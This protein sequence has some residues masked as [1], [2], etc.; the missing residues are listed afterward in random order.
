M[1]NNIVDPDGDVILKLEYPNDPFALE[2]GSPRTRAQSPNSTALTKDDSSLNTLSSL[3]DNAEPGEGDKSELVTFRVSSRHLALA[4]PVFKSALTGEWKESVKTEGEHQINSEGWDTTALS[5]FLKAIHCQYRQ[6]PRSLELE[7]LAKVAVIVDYYAAHQ[8]IEILGPIW[9]NALRSWLPTTTC[10]YRT[11]AL[12][13]CISWVFG[14]SSAFETAT[15]VAI[16]HGHSN[17]TD[18]G[19][20]I[21]GR[22][23][24]DIN[25]NKMLQVSMVFTRLSTLQ[26]DLLDSR[27]GC[28]VECRTMQLGAITRLLN[29]TSLSRYSWLDYQA[30]SVSQLLEEVE[31]AVC[32]TWYEKPQTTPDTCGYYSQRVTHK[33]HECPAPGNAF[34][35]AIKSIPNGVSSLS[36]GLS[37]TDYAKS[38]TESI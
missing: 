22:V 36:R 2:C 26:E 11:I 18:F 8:A 23:V 35:V 20:P 31:A 34:D 32:P 29:S 6:V 30:L 27:K 33:P 13:I 12:W 10:D 7:M 25:R 15:K 5:I 19:L 37:I 16:H 24:D 28:G 1:G 21:P 9:I 4:S 14:D 38:A 17:M 3:Q